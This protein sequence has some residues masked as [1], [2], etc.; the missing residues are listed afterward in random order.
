MDRAAIDRVRGDRRSVPAMARPS[1][2]PIVVWFDD[3]CGVCAASVRLL[4]RRVDTTVTFRPSWEL[5][6]PNLAARADQALLVV[7]PRGLEEGAPAVATLLDRCGPVGR[8]LSIVLGL[9]V[10]DR[11]AARVYR[12]VA[13]NRGAISRR[14]GLPAGCAL[15]GPGAKSPR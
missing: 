15:P 4:R 2:I 11:L 14:L 5:T 3:D 8:V 7:G 6:D 9:P 1:S 13:A 10:I 12:L